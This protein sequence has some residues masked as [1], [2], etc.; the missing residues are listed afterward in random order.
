MSREKWSILCFF[1]SSSGRCG[2][3][4][5]ILPD[6]GKISINFVE[7]G[8]HPPL[9][10]DRNLA[11]QLPQWSVATHWLQWKQVESDFSRKCFPWLRS[12]H[13]SPC[14]RLRTL[15]GYRRLRIYGRIQT[16]NRERP[17]ALLKRGMCTPS[18]FGLSAPGTL[19]AAL[20]QLQAYLYGGKQM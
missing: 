18:V 3:Q 5:D 12:P 7:P 1:K 16:Y 9:E 11:V 2:S 4:R 13:R 6:N 10:S 19:L 20:P 8:G 14:A 17:L 15:V